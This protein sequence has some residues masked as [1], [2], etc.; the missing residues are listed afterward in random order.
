MQDLSFIHA[1]PFYELTALVVLAAVFGCVGETHDSVF[2]RK[3]A[4]R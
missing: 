4:R 3:T 1:S 2:L